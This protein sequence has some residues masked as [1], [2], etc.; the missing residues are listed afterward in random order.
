MANMSY[1][2]FEN[3]IGDMEQLVEAMEN[4]KT[5]EDLDLGA[6]ELR[7]FYRLRSVARNMLGEH[8]RLL[9]ATESDLSD[10]CYDQGE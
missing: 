2:H 10:C 3:T 8:E 1:C 7:A 9:N 6:Y 4:A 5:L